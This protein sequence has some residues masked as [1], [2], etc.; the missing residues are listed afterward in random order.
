VASDLHKR[1]Y[2]ITSD[3][4]AHFAIVFAALIHDV[5]HP[6]LTNRQLIEQCNP[7]AIQYHNQSV[8][9][10]NSITQ[11]RKLLMRDDFI[12]LRRC[13]YTTESEAK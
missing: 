8:A 4:L 2:G 10:Q 7:M 11:A 9:E 13:I 5:D 3:P 12:E 6:G 1:T